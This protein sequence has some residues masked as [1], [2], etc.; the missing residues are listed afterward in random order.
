MFRVQ[1]RLP[2]PP[3]TFTDL[4]TTA[5]RANPGSSSLAV[6]T[7]PS[8]G[9][10]LMKATLP[11]ATRPMTDS[12]LPKVMN[13]A[14]STQNE[15]TYDTHARNLERMG[16]STVSS[17]RSSSPARK[18]IM[19]AIDFV[20]HE[21]SQRGSGSDR[22]F[23]FPPNAISTVVDHGL[24]SNGDGVEYDPPRG[25]ISLYGCFSCRSGK[26]VVKLQHGL[27]GRSTENV[28]QSKEPFSPQA[29]DSETPIM[30]STSIRQWVP[31]QER[32]DDTDTEVTQDLLDIPAQKFSASSLFEP[33]QAFSLPKY[34]KPRRLLE[35]PHGDLLC[36]TAHGLMDRFKCGYERY[37]VSSS[38]RSA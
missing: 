13:V 14:A 31:Q 1:R 15:S 16:A 11:I 34:D 8:P 3:P 2:A 22:P 20:T 38:V 27:P 9:H 30:L 33:Y 25:Q 36:V 37:E 29:R 24:Q 7:E 5:L 21:V 4:S 35:L 32:K 26:F 6:K 23:S 12:P 28:P 10:A 18:Q 19:A 17:T